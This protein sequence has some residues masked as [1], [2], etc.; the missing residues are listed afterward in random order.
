MSTLEQSEAGGTSLA[1]ECL[2]RNTKKSVL[3]RPP[4]NKDQ[5][6]PTL[7][8]HRQSLMEGEGGREVENERWRKRRH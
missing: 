8:P 4:K 7:S 3:F 2:W 6:T 1:L 5:F